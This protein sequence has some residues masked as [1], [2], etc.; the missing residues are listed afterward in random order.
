MR[1]YL[2]DRVVFKSPRSLLFNA[3]KRGDSSINI[4]LTLL[5]EVSI[6]TGRLQRQQEVTHLVPLALYRRYIQIPYV[7]F[8][9]FFTPLENFYRRLIKFFYFLPLCVV[10]TVILAEVRNK[11]TRNHLFFSFFF[12]FTRRVNIPSFISFDA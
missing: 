6:N 9:N 11:I 2:C 4:G 12:N 8:S 7:R 1:F 5:V 3:K 10:I